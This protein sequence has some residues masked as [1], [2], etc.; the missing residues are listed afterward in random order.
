MSGTALAR[1]PGAR[2]AGVGVAIVLAWTAVA[3]LAPA[4]APHPPGTI[5][6]LGPLAPASLAT[7][8]GTDV[9]GRD[10]LSRVIHG[11]RYSLGVPIL[12]AGL[13]SGLGCLLGILASVQRGWLD[14]TLSRV[15]D[16]LI[17]IPHLMFALVIVAA[18]GSSMPVLVGLIALSYAPGAFRVSRALALDIQA[19]DYIA[20]ARAR[21]EGG[22]AE[23]VWLEA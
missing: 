17:S 8:F 12:A 11:A 19:N 22:F 14:G 16:I 9:L 10:M 1:R 2:A 21:G 18:L 6:R 15:A 23:N 20:V 5:L 4:I 3:I 13:A 7:P